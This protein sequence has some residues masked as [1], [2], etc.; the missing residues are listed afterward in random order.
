MDRTP[1]I[2]AGSKKRWCLL[3]GGMQLMSAGLCLPATGYADTNMLEA[4]NSYF[5][6]VTSYNSTG[7][8]SVYY[9]LVAANEPAPAPVA[10]AQPL[11]SALAS[12]LVP[13]SIN[14]P[15]NYGV[16]RVQFLVNGL[17]VAELAAPPYLYSWDTST[18]VRGDYV[19]SVK[20]FDAAGNQAASQELTV[21]VAGDTVPPVVS[22]A[23][24]ANSTAG[25]SVVLSASARD[26]V[27]VTRTEI[28]LD[29]ILV[30]ASEQGSVSY[31][32][33][34]LSGSNGPHLL[35]AKAYDAAGNV[36]FCDP[37]AVTVFNDTTA[38]VVSVAAPVRSGALSGTVALSA[39]A[40]DDV[41]VSKVEFYLNGSLQASSTSAPYTF[42]WR[43]SAVANGAYTL[44]AKAFDAAGNVGISAPLALTV[45]NDTS[46][47]VLSIN[48]VSTPTTSSSQTISGSV[49]DNV[50]VATVTVQVGS[51]A[52][53]PAAL[54]G[55]SWNLALSGLAVGSNLITVRA[56]DRSGNVATA[57]TSVT[58]QLPTVVSAPYTILDAQ[59]AMQIASGQLVPTKAQLQRLDVAPYVNGKSVPNGKID[60]NDVVIILSK[61][62]VK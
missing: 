14:A 56:T 36:G 40:S 57:S 60:N 2:W 33:D 50:A 17:Q 30:N 18:L 16:T 24:P 59:I 62:I 23:A 41:A 4:D 31:T 45:F 11:T 44:T 8:E 46:A 19:I 13:V 52:A 26:N 27:N 47:P 22:F 42:S 15:E 20:A 28:Y 7:L 29:G 48:A 58:V 34:T 43:T 61:L 21:G 10:I 25:G 35:S 51:A 12:D 5:F 9:N 1:R 37:L 55:S 49:S 3:L 39:A 54:T 6:A 32:W 53:I 38:P